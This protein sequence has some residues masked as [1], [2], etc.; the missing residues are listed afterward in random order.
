MVL[1]CGIWWTCRPSQPSNDW[2]IWDVSQ[3]NVKPL[4]KNIN[5]MTVNVPSTNRSQS[6]SRCI[7]LYTGGFYSHRPSLDCGA[8]MSWKWL[9]E[10][11][12]MF[13]FLLPVDPVWLA[14]L[15]AYSSIPYTAISSWLRL[16]SQT[17]HEEINPFVVAIVLYMVT[18]ILLLLINYPTYPAINYPNDLFPIPN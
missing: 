4:L 7:H 16:T 14:S 5:S 18:N 6:I 10:M 15:V 3:E 13:Y 9:L 12:E 1:N 8:L 2:M 17:G 11:Y